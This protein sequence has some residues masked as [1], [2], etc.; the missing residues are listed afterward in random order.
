MRASLWLVGAAAVLGA[1]FG[2]AACG[3]TSDSAS[4]AAAAPPWHPRPLTD[5]VYERTPERQVRG[6]YLVRGILQCFL[7]HSERDWTKPGAPPKAGR[8]GAGAVWWNKAWLVAPNLTPD[9]E[10]GIGR[11][12]DDM[13]ARAI[14]E[15][16]SHDGRP[17]HPQMWSSSF[18][19]LTDEEVAS[20]IVYLRALKP[21][22]HPLPPTAIPPAEAAKI[23]PP[24]AFTGQP[25]EF[26]SNLARGGHLVALADCA[27]CHTSW[28]TPVNPG[29]FGGGNPIELSGV[30]AYSANITSDPSGIPYYDAALFREVMRTGH[31][32]SRPLSPVM[33][34][35]VFGHLDDADLDAIFAYLSAYR[36]A[37][38]L[39]DNIEAPTTC[40]VCQGSHPLGEYNRPVESH[41]APYSAADWKD[42]VGAYRLETDLTLVIALRGRTLTMQEGQGG[43]PCDL[44]TEDGRRFVCDGGLDEVEFVRE[45]G[46]VTHLIDNRVDVARKV[47]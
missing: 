27:G 22:R 3:A 10:T 25:L 41:P 6:E 12:T 42:A 18:S 16:I 26:V 36:P 43:K 5:V 20:V 21:I 9:T 13:L 29:L 30:H 47:R 24:P 44:T 46:R 2:A 31:V 8:E 45:S 40:P 33:P 38:H 28:Y 32:K 15:G 1:A 34:W 19:D 11:W 7:C 4:P 17:L 39:I 37:H 35:V 14:R 23:E